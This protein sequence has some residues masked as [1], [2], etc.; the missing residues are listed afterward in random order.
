MRTVS[1]SAM[2]VFLFVTGFSAGCASAP[3]ASG[4]H[5]TP[6]G[7]GRLPYSDAD[8]DFMSGMIPHHAQAVIMAGWAP[9]HGARTDVSILCERIVVGQRDEIVAMQTW[10]GDRVQAVPDA[11]S[12]R[13]TMKMNG[14][15]HEMLMPGMLTD[16]E[17]ATLDGVRGPEFD[18]LFLVGMI[19]HHQG[20]I[21]MVDTLF[22]AFGAAQ[23]ETIFKF[24]SDVYADQ[25]I[26]IDRMNDMLRDGGRPE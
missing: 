9:S 19:R 6:P 25:S 16:E 2:A 22:K 24:A 17:M 14:V 8:V 18:R 21:D 11:T 5:A 10:L 4:L 1:T 20:A 7:L 23:D 13:H 3:S 26:E 12:T 15:E